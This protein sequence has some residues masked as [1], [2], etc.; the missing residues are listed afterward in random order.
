MS[1]DHISLEERVFYA[2]AAVTA[3]ANV[4]GERLNDDPETYIT[5]LL[6]DLRHLCEHAGLEF[7][8]CDRLGA[9]HFEAESPP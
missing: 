3:Y 8:E 9:L 4:K 6:A 5:D 1:E 2:R 7:A